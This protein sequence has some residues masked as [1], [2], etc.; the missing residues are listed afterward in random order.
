MGKATASEIAKQALDIPRSSIYDLL[1][2]LQHHGFVSSFTKNEK[3]YFQVEHIE[4]VIDI[5]EQEK[6]ALTTQQNA[7]RSVADMFNQ[8]K[9][10]TA[11]K[12]GVRFFEGKKG[13]LAVHREIINARKTLYLIGDL[14]AVIHTFPHAAVEDNFAEFKTNKIVRKAMMIPNAAGKQYL[15]NAGLNEYHHVKW[16]PQAM[17]LDTDTLIWEGHVAI[18][19]YTQQLNAV[20]I[21]NPTIYATFVTWFEMMWHS[22][23]KE[24]ASQEL[25]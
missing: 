3:M 2:S 16:L 20:V 1:Q 12:P 4:H 18:I 7:F 9:T 6:R 21:D 10:G 8:M 22:I 24:V 25:K 23:P 5:L 19:D 15:R 13:I 17:K 11:Y 14:A